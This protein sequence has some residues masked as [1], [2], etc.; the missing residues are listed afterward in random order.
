MATQKQTTITKKKGRAKKVI[1]HDPLSMADEKQEGEATMQSAE[2]PEM[3]KPKAMESEATE[4]LSV[5]KKSGNS[6]DLGG[7]LVINEV[8]AYR[9]VLLGALQGDGDLIIDGTEIEQIDGAGLQL[10]AAFA[11]EAEKMQIMFKWCGA[12]SVLCEASAQL[13]LAEVLRLNQICQAA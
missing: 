3:T 9:N 1:V 6:I 10:L 2:E 13:G 7:S 4:G 12:S 8:E 11:L 5:T